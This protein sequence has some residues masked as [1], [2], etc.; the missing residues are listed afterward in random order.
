MVVVVVVAVAGT[1]IMTTVGVPVV[2]TGPKV[3]AAAHGRSAVVV[4]IRVGFA[5][6]A[7]GTTAAGAA[8]AL[9]VLV[10]VMV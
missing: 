3:L 5:V 4:E 8:T 2:A 6:E 1:V 9:L 10:V 7:T